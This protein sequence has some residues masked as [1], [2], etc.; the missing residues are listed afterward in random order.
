MIPILYTVPVYL[1]DEYVEDMEVAAD[2]IV[3]ISDAGNLCYM[4]LSDK[5]RLVIALSKAQL[6]VSLREQ[7]NQ[8]HA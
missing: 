8:E 3:S 5:R 2:H 7:F 6:L 4:D 1:T